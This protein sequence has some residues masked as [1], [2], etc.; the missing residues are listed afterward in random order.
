M[1]SSVPHWSF[2]FVTGVNAQINSQMSLCLAYLDCAHVFQGSS[3]G[4]RAN[5]GQNF[6]FEICLRHSYSPH[7]LAKPFQHNS[8]ISPIHSLIDGTICF[9]PN[10]WTKIQQHQ[11]FFSTKFTHMPTETASCF[12]NLSKCNVTA[13]AKCHD[14]MILLMFNTD[15]QLAQNMCK[16]G[17]W[18]FSHSNCTQVMDICCLHIVLVELFKRMPCFLFVKV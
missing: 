4:K 12:Q 15:W 10:S 3:R 16:V 17:Q 9:E 2:T 13:I 5:L 14:K 8:Q 18:K 1:C 6:G 11:I 7:L